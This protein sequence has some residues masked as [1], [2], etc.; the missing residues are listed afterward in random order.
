MAGTRV[1]RLHEALGIDGG[2]V[3]VV[4][5]ER[6]ERRRARLAHAAG[7]GQVHHDAEEVGAQRRAALERVEPAQ[8]AD[9]GLL[10]DLLGDLLGGDVLARD[11]HERGVVAID[12]LGEGALVAGA[13]RGQQLGLAAPLPCSSAR[14]CSRSPVSIG[15]PTLQRPA[16]ARAARGRNDRPIAYR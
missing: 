16:A 3:L 15:A 6:R 1:G 8:Q 2:P 13:Q 4:A 7:A 11:A 9:P 12:E 10:G 14:A 5:H